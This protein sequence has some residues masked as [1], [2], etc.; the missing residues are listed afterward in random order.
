MNLLYDALGWVGAVALL[1]AYALVSRG[2]V[3][4][5]GATFQ[6]LN[7]VGAVGLLVNGV[8]HH[9]WPSAALN[10]V[11]LLVGVA[12]V[13]ALRRAGRVESGPLDNDRTGAGQR[14]R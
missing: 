7:L 9:A 10:A 2:R 8:Y 4:G 11:W 3:A 6:V 13:V 5:D 12:A 1:G 14:P